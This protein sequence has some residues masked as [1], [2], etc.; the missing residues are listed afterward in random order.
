VRLRERMNPVLRQVI[1]MVSSD[2]EN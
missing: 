1:L 2:I